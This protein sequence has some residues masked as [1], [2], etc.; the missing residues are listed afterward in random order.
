VGSITFSWKPL[1]LIGAVL[2]S[3]AGGYFI[4]QTG[5]TGKT[6]QLSS[7]LERLVAVNKELREQYLRAKA[8]AGSARV[9]VASARSEVSGLRA[10]TSKY[11]EELAGVG[12]HLNEI[13]G[14]LGSTATTLEGVVD[15]IEGI[16]LLVEGL[17]GN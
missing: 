10:E 1:A 6:Q 2:L 17:P 16:K 4:S 13:A 7:N 9:E 5:N 8:E 11:R 14:S 3:A 12:R 15:V